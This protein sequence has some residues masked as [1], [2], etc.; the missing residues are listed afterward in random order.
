MDTNVVIDFFNATLPEKAKNL[1]FTI[2][3]IISVISHIEL[4]SSTKISDQELFHLQNFIKA[5]TVYDNINADIVKNTI[6]IR[7]AHKIKTPDAI[8]A[9]TAIVYDL[10]LITRNT[11]DFK[12]IPNLKIIDPHSF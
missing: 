10:T 1:L 7:K 2:E 9:A 12:N 11:A 8:I 3:P 4:F 6:A 5:A